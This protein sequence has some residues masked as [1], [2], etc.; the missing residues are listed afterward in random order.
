MEWTD[1]LDFSHKGAGEQEQNGKATKF[2]RAA[3]PWLCLACVCFW[4]ARRNLRHEPSR[5]RGAP[6]EVSAPT[7]LPKL[8]D[9]ESYDIAAEAAKVQERKAWQ[10][11]RITFGKA[12]PQRCTEFKSHE[13]S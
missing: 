12:R 7:S 8:W 10:R 9:D 2:P 4:Y 5:D 3:Q 1:Q 13:S 6:C 11:D